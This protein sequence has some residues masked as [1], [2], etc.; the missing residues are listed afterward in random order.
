MELDSRVKDGRPT[1]DDVEQH[2]ELLKEFSAF[3]H[4]TVQKETGTW[5]AE[6]RSS[7]QELTKFVKAKGRSR[8]QGR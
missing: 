6:F 4:D 5:V 8:G 1:A 3:I 2:I 7:L